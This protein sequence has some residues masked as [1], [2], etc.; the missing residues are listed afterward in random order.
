MSS[1]DGLQDDCRPHLGE[2]VSTSRGDA[3]K[4]RVRVLLIRRPARGLLIY[5]SWILLRFYSSSY[6]LHTCV[7]HRLPY[8][9]NVA[10]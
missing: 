3:R 5:A 6:M 7:V 8:R 2:R 9:N 1:L 4:W 10:A